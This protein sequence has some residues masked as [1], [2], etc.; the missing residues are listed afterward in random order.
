MC[1]YI[2]THT[3]I[4]IFDTYVCYLFSS[5]PRKKKTQFNFRG[6]FL[7]TK[8]YNNRKSMKINVLQICGAKAELGKLND[9]GFRTI[10]SSF[11]SIY[12][13]LLKI[14]YTCIDIHSCTSAQIHDVAKKSFQLRKKNF[15]SQLLLHRFNA[16]D[17][18]LITIT[19][20]IVISALLCV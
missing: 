18:R 4:K 20:L 13:G 11:I 3:S 12:I 7:H 14:L 5:T 16:A 19:T 10:F 6:F 8:Q 9:I 2:H 17:T 1:I 15:I